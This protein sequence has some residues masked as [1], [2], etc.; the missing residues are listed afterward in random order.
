MRILAD[1]PRR[2]APLGHLLLQ[3]DV[4]GHHPSLRDGALHH[5]QQVIGIDRLG[6]KVGR[7]LAHRGHGV[8]N[9][10]VRGHDDDGQLGVELLGRSQDAEPVAGG[11]LEIGEHHGRARLTEL[12]NRFWLVSRFEDE[13]SLRLERMAQHGA[14]RILVFDKEDGKRRYRCHQTCFMSTRLSHHHRISRHDDQP[15]HALVASRDD[16]DPSTNGVCRVRRRPQEH[17]V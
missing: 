12:M 13:V 10:A 5:Q 16:L 8:L 4:L 15:H 7:P 2:P 3:E 1:D 11:Q 9:A 17:N 14:Q 6:E